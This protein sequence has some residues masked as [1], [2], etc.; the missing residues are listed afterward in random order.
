M[1]HNILVL[2]RT[3]Y[4]QAHTSDLVWASSSLASFKLLEVPVA[5]LDIAYRL[6]ASC[7]VFSLHFAS[8]SGSL[9]GRLSSGSRS[10]FRGGARAA[11]EE[12]AGNTMTNYATGSNATSSGG[13]LGHNARSATRLGSSGSGMRSR[14][15]WCISRR[16]SSRGS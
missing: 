3:D 16:C 9:L 2:A 10:L 8:R 15:W 1:R 11:T 7:K 4:Q 12:Q 13:H 5:T 6:Y 14:S